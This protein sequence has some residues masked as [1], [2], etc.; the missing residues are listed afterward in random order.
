MG[1]RVQ[2]FGNEVGPVRNEL[3]I[4]TQDGAKRT[5]HLRGSVIVRLQ[6]AHRGLN[7]GVQHGN[8]FF[9]GEA[10]GEGGFHTW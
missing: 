1:V 9:G 2:C 3:G 5:F 8:V 10:E 6:S 7:K 4:E